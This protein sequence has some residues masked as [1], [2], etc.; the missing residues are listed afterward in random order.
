MLLDEHPPRRLGPAW[1]AQPRVAERRL[2]PASRRSVAASPTRSRWPGSPRTPRRSPRAAASS[3]STPTPGPPPPL[4]GAGRSRAR[5][6]TVAAAP[7]ASAA[8]PVGLSA[9]SCSPA[10]PGRRVRVPPQPVDDAG[11]RHLD[12][13]R[14]GPAHRQ[15]PR[16]KRLHPARQRDRRELAPGDR[17][18]LVASDGEPHERPERRGL[19][20]HDVGE[21]AS[22]GLVVLR[23]VAEHPHRWMLAHVA[24]RDRPR[25]RRRDCPGRPATRGRA[26]R[27]PRRRA[28]AGCRRSRQQPVSN[29][30]EH[31]LVEREQRRHG[32]RRRRTA[33]LHDRVRAPTGSSRRPAPAAPWAAGST[34]HPGRRS[35]PTRRGR[36]RARPAARRRRTRT[37]AGPARSRTPERRT[38][39]HANGSSGSASAS[40]RSSGTASSTSGAAGRADDGMSSTTGS[41]VSGSTGICD[42]RRSTRRTASCPPARR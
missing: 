22:R 24:Q 3:T 20:Q 7:P 16:R 27:T 31:Q 39:R 34:A 14:V 33:V 11:Q 30:V 37:T 13:L 18:R 10:R 25:R 17:V 41:P 4:R 19:L 38:C 26:R 5:S 42:G 9:L 40:H 1:P 2:P 21:P 8:S 15:R 12:V 28:A 23:P 29:G 35:A 36:R 32:R 6:A